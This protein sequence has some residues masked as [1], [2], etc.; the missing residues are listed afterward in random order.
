MALNTLSVMNVSLAQI[1]NPKH[2]NTINI[3]TTSHP[4]I[5]LRRKAPHLNSRM[6]SWWLLSNSQNGIA[7]L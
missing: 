2:Q 3:G 7:I 1:I 6:G 4:R 5:E